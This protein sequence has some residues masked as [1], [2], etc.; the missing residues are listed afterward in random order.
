MVIAPKYIIAGS[1]NQYRLY[2]R[3]HYFDKTQ[4]KFVSDVD[5]IKGLS[6]ISGVF[7]GTWADRDDIMDI[8][9][10]ICIIKSRINDWDMPLE[11]AKV[12]NKKCI[13]QTRQN[14]PINVINPKPVNNKVFG[15]TISHILIDELN[16]N[17]SRRRA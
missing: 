15:T 5:S 11:I 7:I 8:I 12:Y 10:Q 6:D 13:I 4:Y 16:E 3:E 1:Y 14:P 17:H 9:V 2:V